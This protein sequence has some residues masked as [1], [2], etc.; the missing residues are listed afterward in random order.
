MLSQ[1]IQ[2]SHDSESVANLLAIPGRKSLNK[3]RPPP[4]D[5]M[6]SHLSA[7]ES[8]EEEEDPQGEIHH[9]TNSKMATSN[10]P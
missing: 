4:E 7:T 2:N 1:S 10:P 9:T 6:M 3:M 8:N 5:S